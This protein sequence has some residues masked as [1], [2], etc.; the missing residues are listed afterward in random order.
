[1]KLIASRMLFLGVVSPFDINAR[2]KNTLLLLLHELKLGVQIRADNLG[3]SGL[4][5]LTWMFPRPG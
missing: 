3:L 4:A 1:M 5:Y 2:E